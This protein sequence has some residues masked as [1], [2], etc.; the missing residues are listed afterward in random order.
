MSDEGIAK[1][2]REQLVKFLMDNRD[3]YVEVRW[4]HLF[5]RLNT[6]I[7]IVM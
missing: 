5:M 3:A 4:V 1:T 2:M 6:L 7:T